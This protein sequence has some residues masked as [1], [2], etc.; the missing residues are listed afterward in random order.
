MQSVYIQLI[1]C[2]CSHPIVLMLFTHKPIFAARLVFIHC[3]RVHSVFYHSFSIQSTLLPTLPPPTVPSLKYIYLII[4]NLARI[5]ENSLITFSQ[6]VCAINIWMD[7]CTDKHRKNFECC[8]VGC[9]TKT[10]FQ[11]KKLFIPSRLPKRHI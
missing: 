4:Y 11:K 3:E 1:L 7:I 10:L 6:T 5:P 8:P 2:D 9:F